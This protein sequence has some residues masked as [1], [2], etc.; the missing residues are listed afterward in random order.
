MFGKIDLDKGVLNHIQKLM[1]TKG[2][3]RTIFIKKKKKLV[4]NLKYLIYI[5]T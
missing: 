1:K 5:T 4:L 2:V 3:H